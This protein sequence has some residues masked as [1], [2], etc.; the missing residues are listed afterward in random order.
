VIKVIP[1]NGY[2]WDTKHGNVM[3]A[4]KIM[5]GAM[6]GKTFDDSIEGRVSL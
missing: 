4:V 6:V 5:F 2:Y 1:D 3:A